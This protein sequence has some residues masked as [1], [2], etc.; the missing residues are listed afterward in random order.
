MCNEIKKWLPQIDFLNL[1]QLFGGDGGSRKDS[2]AAESS[3]LSRHLRLLTIIL[4]IIQI[5]I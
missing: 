3:Y 2:L 1:R 5:I 4:T